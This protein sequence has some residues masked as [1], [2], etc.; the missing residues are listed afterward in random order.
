V[1][2]TAEDTQ[3]EIQRLRLSQELSAVE[4]RLSKLRRQ[5]DEL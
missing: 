2:A 4:M 5:P 1:R 3:K